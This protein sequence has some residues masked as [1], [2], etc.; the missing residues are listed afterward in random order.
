MILALGAKTE[1]PSINQLIFY[2][3]ENLITFYLYYKL[4][5]RWGFRGNAI[6][7]HLTSIRIGVQ[8]LCLYLI[9]SYGVWVKL[10]SHPQEDIVQFLLK[11]AYR[12]ILFLIYGFTYANHKQV[13]TEER[14]SS[15]LK[16]RVLQQE[17]DQLRMENELLKERNR[18][19]VSQITPHF[20]FNNF[21]AMHRD[22]YLVAPKVAQRILSLSKLLQYSF[23]ALSRNINV[24]LQMEIKQVERFIGLNQLEERNLNVKF[25]YPDVSADLTVIPFS[26]LTL[27]ENMF[28]H[29]DLSNASYPGIIKVELKNYK[30]IIS[31]HN[32]IEV[33]KVS[34]G[35]GSGLD[36]LKQ[37]LAYT[38]GDT[39]SME[40]WTDGRFF[41]VR[42]VIDL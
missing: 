22:T 10:L 23:G 26:I 33:L 36:N 4:L 34:T 1:V 31:T 42:V 14:I 7:R 15:T 37:R 35:F 41:E 30:I 40:T 6:G 32:L 20:V 18:N 2:Y 24:S 38:Y 29:G 25:S 8:I 13:L 19:L 21:A 16:E 3:L 39:A 28:K 27:A 9:I 5:K 12:C 17:V 11:N